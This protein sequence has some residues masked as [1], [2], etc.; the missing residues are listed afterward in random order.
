MATDLAEWLVR[1]GVPFREAHHMVGRFVRGCAG[2]GIPLDQASLAQMREAI[3]LAEAECLS[4]FSAPRSVAGRSLTGGTA[5]N[6]VD[7]QLAAWEQR[8]Q[9]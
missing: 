1:K 6:Q 3:P 7:R 2:R 9:A 5:P 4:L 8:L